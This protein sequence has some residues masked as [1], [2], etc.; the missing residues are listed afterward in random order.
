MG[1]GLH[2]NKK[3]MLFFLFVILFLLVTA[4]F[5]LHAATP[6]LFHEVAFRPEIIHRH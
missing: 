2:V 5:L 6:S 3:Q 4:V 1:I